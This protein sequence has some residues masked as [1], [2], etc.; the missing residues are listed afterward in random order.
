MSD[1]IMQNLKTTEDFGGLAKGRRAKYRM[2]FDDSAKAVVKTSQKW[3]N[4]TPV[5]GQDRITDRVVSGVD[6]VQELPEGAELPELK[7][8]LGLEKS[9]VADPS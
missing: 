6:R 7:V 1:L 8:Y 5:S 4:I 9:R 3:I 2:V